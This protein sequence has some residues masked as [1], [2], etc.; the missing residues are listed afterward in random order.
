[1]VS[2]ESF[3]QARLT[4]LQSLNVNNLRD[5]DGALQPWIELWNPS[6]GTVLSVANY[7]LVHD[8]INWVFPSV[9]IMPDERIVVFASGQDKRE[10]TAPLHTN[11]T[12]NPAGGTL[13][14]RHSN[15][16]VLS[17]FNYPALSPG[18][19]WGRDEGD[20]AITPVWTGVYDT[21][22][23]GERN[24]LR[25]AAITGEV[26]FDQSSQAFLGTLTVSLSQAAPEAGA[27]IRYTTDKSLPTAAS[28]LY[29][30]PITVNATRMIRARVFKPGLL[31]GPTATQAY[32]LLNATTRNFNTRI[33]L[34]VLSSFSTA[35]PP[36]DGDQEAFLWLWEPD[37]EGRAAFTDPPTLAA[38]VAINR[39]GSSTLGNPKFN[40]NLNLQTLNDTDNDG[41]EVDLLGMT[42][43]DDWVFH[44]PYDFD[45]ALLRNPLMYQLSRSIGRYAA[46]SRMA[47][48]FI[49]V[50]G[51]SLNFTGSNSSASD[52]FGVYNI[53]ERLRRNKDR[54][55]LRKLE[56]Y[57]HANSALTG[58]Y[59]WKVDR[60]GTGETGFRA[61]G[62]AL[63]YYY[64]QEREL[65]SPQRAPQAA[66]LTSYINDFYAALTGPEWKNPDTGYAAWLDAPSVIDSH[67]LNLWAYNVD[68]F[69][70]ST[71]WQK[72]AGGKIAA[73]PIWDFDRSLS[74]TDTG[75]EKPRDEN[76]VEWGNGRWPEGGFFA[77]HW[78]S[79][80][81]Q[82]IDFYQRYIDRWQ[83]LRR[84]PFAEARVNAR[85]DS[86]NETI[87]TSAVSRDLNHWQRPKRP[88][89]GP[90]ARN[91]VT[92]AS[93]DAEIQRI[94]DYLQVRAEFFDSQWVGPV[95]PSVPAGA[96][97][98]GT[99]VTLSGPPGV[100]IY[101]T[102]DGSDP[103][104]LGGG[105]PVSAARL[106][107][108][109]PIIIDGPRHAARTGLRRH[110][111]CAQRRESQP[112]PRQPMGRASRG[113]L[114]ARPTR[115]RRRPRHQ[116]TEFQSA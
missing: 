108:G 4:E 69:R 63:T 71:F 33:P 48:V 24:S 92:R 41:R 82:D 107:D 49:D 6:P 65:K 58:G 13:E 116:R 73:G 18:V 42:A 95:A 31:P 17:V 90:H 67:L 37:A 62:Q 94:K 53:M 36:A 83:E 46:D 114:Y 56:T 89:T 86:L 5:Q 14:L 97:A 70:L 2:G 105:A 38:R 113:A 44:A 85:V 22:T 102:V 96:V 47:E 19:S 78:W 10:A 30:G 45:R 101:Y 27:E 104:P 28:A 59:I 79:L 60:L 57:D 26:V 99:P 50:T 3:A 87:G 81:F 40:L 84:G 111:H 32:L 25:G 103:R 20:T 8:G 12:L 106:W 76:P 88:W 110:A 72:D 112:A 23:P 68:A 64:P 35:A 54:I 16:S 66:Y 39:R 34:A 43:H 77:A 15:G 29:E 51:G 75:Y 109:E 7:R 74:S 115:R 80:L 55:D 11:F 9:R 100:P 52:Y 91:P 1:M 21:P 93:Q 61:G 98:A